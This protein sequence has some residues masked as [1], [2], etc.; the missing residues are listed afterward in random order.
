[1]EGTTL[2]KHIGVNEKDKESEVKKWEG[3]SDVILGRADW[4][5]AWL[6]GE[7]KCTLILK[8][9]FGLTD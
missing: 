9:S 7:K 6:E 5:A 8:T 2:E 4:F 1:M 3:L